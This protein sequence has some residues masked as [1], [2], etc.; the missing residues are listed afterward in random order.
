MIRGGKNEKQRTREGSKKQKGTI[1][2]MKDDGLEGKKKMQ[3]DEAKK[4]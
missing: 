1:V 3:M 2:R 4:T